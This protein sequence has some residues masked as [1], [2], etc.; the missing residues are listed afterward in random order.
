MKNIRTRWPLI[1]LAGIIIF[2]TTGIK[3]A[4]YWEFGPGDWTYEQYTDY[5]SWSLAQ[6]KEDS[7]YIVIY[8]GANWCPTCKRFEKK[9]LEVVDQI[10]SNITILAAD[11][12]RDEALVKEYGVQV[13]STTVYLDK[14]WI[15]LKKNRWGD[16]SL[17]DILN[18]IKSF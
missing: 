8:F 2:H 14:D 16:H 5:T 4:V 15:L 18:T 10:P 12:D 13:Q 7:H 6:A 9:L 3:P 11:I 1:I 17:Q